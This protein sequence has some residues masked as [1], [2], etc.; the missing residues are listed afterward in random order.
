MSVDVERPQGQPE[1][2]RV[3]SIERNG[4]EPIPESERHGKPL[5][6]FWVWA[7]ANISILGV[8][9]GT[10]LVAFYSLNLGQA[11]RRRAR[12]HGPV[13]PARRVHQPRGKKGSAPTLVLSRAAF[14]VRGQRGADGGELARARRVGDRAR[15][16]RDPRVEAIVDRLGIGSGDGVLALAFL[17]IAAAT[18]AIG[19]ARPRDDRPDPDALH[20]RLRA[21]DRRLHRVRPARHRVGQGLGSLPS[22]SLFA[23]FIGG[24]SVVMAG[25]GIGWVNAGADY[26]RY[27]PRSASSRGVVGWTTF[28]A[29][30]PLLVLIPLGILLAAGNPDLASSANPIGDLARRPADLVPRAVPADRGRRA[31]G[32]CGPRHLL[33]GAEPADPRREDPPA[34]LGRLRRRADGP[35]QHLHPVHRE[36]LH[37]TLHRVPGD[38]R[39]PARLVGGDLPGRLLPLPPRRATSSA[40]STTRAAATAPS[41]PAGLIAFRV[42]AFIGLGLVSPPRRSSAGPATSLGSRVSV[43][44]QGA[45][46]GSSIGLFIAFL[47][48]ASPYAIASPAAGYHARRATR[49]RAGTLTWTPPTARRDR[50][51]G[52]VPRPVEPVARAGFEE[53]AAPIGRLVEAFGDRVVH[54]RFTLPE[55]KPGSWAPY[56]ERF[57]PVTHPGERALVR[58]RGT[59]PRAGPAVVERPIFNAWGD[60]LR[61]H[62]GGSGDAGVVWRRDRLLRDRHRPAG[63]RRRGLRSG[64]RRRLSRLERRGARGRDLGPG[65]IRAADRDHL[66]RRGDRALAVRRSP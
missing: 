7:A 53:L 17:L 25:L 28:G 40:T 63:G 27:L 11:L 2:D 8:S 41:T 47:V 15:G 42:A 54:T 22:G 24:M 29:S 57:D 58:V 37:R 5:D 46:A 1:S 61:E 33:V 4:I 32:G 60:E 62:R 50:H 59:V 12:R 45:V 23:G 21:A 18:I 14:G 56:Y 13:V 20:V 34:H 9:Y 49:R 48:A 3:W 52:A 55:T 19:S 10:Y 30:L 66:G 6:L 26:S 39:R 35:R 36:G 31:P 64:R 16:A 44:R 43:A 51:A 65:W 38:A